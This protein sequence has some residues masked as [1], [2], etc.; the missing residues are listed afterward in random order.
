MKTAKRQLIDLHHAKASIMDKILFDKDVRDLTG[1]EIEELASFIDCQ[2]DR[3]YANRKEVE[4]TN[5]VNHFQRY[6]T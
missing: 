1:Q 5:I 4:H 3:Y 6:L 2:L